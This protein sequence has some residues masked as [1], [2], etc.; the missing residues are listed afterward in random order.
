MSRLSFK[1]FCTEKY[2]DF[3]SIPSNEVYK[4]F[5]ENGVI[6]MLNR[7]YDIL[8]GFGFEYIVRDI[9]QYVFNVLKTCLNRE[10]EPTMPHGTIRA[11]TLPAIVNLIMEKYN[12][13]EDHAMKMFYHSH[14]GSCYSDD[15]SGLYGQS[16]LYVFSLFAEEFEKESRLP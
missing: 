14:T 8:H 12:T 9:D 2:A 1:A 16:A 7:D 11:A 10:S 6:Q 15:D 4:L 3:K 13:D 5:E